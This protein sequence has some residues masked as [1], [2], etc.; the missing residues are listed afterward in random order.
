ME[1][2][3]IFALASFALVITV[4]SVM[5]YFGTRIAH[6]T[7]KQGLA[8]RAADVRQQYGEFLLGPE[9]YWGIWL[10]RTKADGLRL[11]VH[12]HLDEEV[13]TIHKPMLPT[14]SDISYFD[15]GE[16][17]Y[18][19]APASALSTRMEYRRKGDPRVLYSSI[20]RIW[21]TRLFRQDSDIELCTV[22]SAT[23]F[24]D[25]TSVLREGKEIGR[26][27]SM[28]KHDYCSRVLSLQTGSLTEVEAMILLMARM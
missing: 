24:S 22:K 20:T 5:W 3:E 15:L 13:T 26:I 19:V 12:N 14:T 1:G 9:F 11:L 4:A 27:I 18:S 7:E 6:A 10:G 8:Y 2:G 25:Y 21:T 23:V 16:T 17:R 28:G